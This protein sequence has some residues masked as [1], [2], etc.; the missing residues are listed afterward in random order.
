M[1]CLSLNILE[2][3]IRVVTVSKDNLKDLFEIVDNTKYEVPVCIICENILDSSKDLQLIF[4][5]IDICH[6]NYFYVH[7]KKELFKNIKTYHI[8]YNITDDG[9]EVYIYS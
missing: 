3:R 7:C 2:K 6:V 4:N 9:K 5:I 1:D 8:G